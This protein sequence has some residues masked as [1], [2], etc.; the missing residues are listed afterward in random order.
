MKSID[1]TEK[2]AQLGCQWATTNQ[3]GQRSS[4]SAAGKSGTHAQIQ[5]PHVTSLAT[6]HGEA[7][8][9]K[10][11]GYLSGRQVR[12]ASLTTKANEVQHQVEWQEAQKRA[13]WDGDN[14]PV[15]HC[16]PHVQQ[17]WGHGPQCEQ[18]Y[19]LKLTGNRTGQIWW[20][21]ECQLR[22]TLEKRRL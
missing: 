3:Q 16:G 18:Q 8:K 12:N 10:S 19:M 4:P 17:K 7:E 1:H 21:S 20:Q 6:K 11:C 15:G 2:H 13:E 5:R 9:T 22:H 14:I